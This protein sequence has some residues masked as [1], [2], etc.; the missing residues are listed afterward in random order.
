M[1]TRHILFNEDVNGA[2]HMPDIVLG[3]L[4]IFVPSS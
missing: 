3:N 2:I 4:K 1:I